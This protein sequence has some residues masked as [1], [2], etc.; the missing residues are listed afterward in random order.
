MIA[1]PGCKAQVPNKEGLTHKYIGTCPGCWEIFLS[2]SVKEFENFKELNDIHRLTV[3]TYAV[4]HPG[5][6]GRLSIQSV[7]VHLLSL[8]SVLERGLPYKQAV[9]AIRKASRHS[10]KFKWL[11]PPSKNGSLTILD[12]NQ[13]KNFEDHKKLVRDWAQDVWQSWRAHHDVIKKLAQ[14]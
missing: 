7:T 9:V 5:V 12:V 11:T 4:Q 1:C 8:Y 2:V 14:I 10:S 13:A 3:D 6:P